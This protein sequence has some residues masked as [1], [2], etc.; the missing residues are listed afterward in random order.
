MKSRMMISILV[1]AMTAAL[2]GGATMAWFT[3]T[4]NISGNTFAAGRVEISLSGP[5]SAK[6][7][8]NVENMA[9]GDP[10][11]V[12]YLHLK[13]EGTLPILFRMYLDN[14]DGTLQN[15]LM[16]KITQNPSGYDYTGMQ[17]Q[18]ANN[19]H[20]THLMANLVGVDNALN[21]LIAAGAGWALPA[22]YTDVYKIEVWL[23][24]TVGNDFQGATFSGTL[25][26]EATQF[27]NQDL[28]DVSWVQ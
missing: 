23:P 11:T 25:K 12:R 13:N 19:D 17:T 16:V 9:P 10:A 24:N 2:I 18:G 28:D 22:G 14:V 1:I 15:A 8:F 4:K 20:G 7:P 6:L 5:D 3:D 21:N 27:N 26:V